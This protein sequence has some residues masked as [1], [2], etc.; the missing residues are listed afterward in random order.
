MWNNILLPGPR[1]IAGTN[2]YNCFY[3][4]VQLDCKVARI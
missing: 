3:L 1:D 2:Q 4:N